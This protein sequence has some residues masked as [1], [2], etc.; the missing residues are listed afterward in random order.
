M[1]QPLIDARIPISMLIHLPLLRRLSCLIQ[2]LSQLALPQV[3]LIAREPKLVEQRRSRKAKN[4]R[5][6]T[7]RQRDGEFKTCRD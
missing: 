3:L 7:G 6:C 2:R 5:K 1:R 4:N